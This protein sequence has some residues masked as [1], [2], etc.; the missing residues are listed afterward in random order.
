MQ[1]Q[2]IATTFYSRFTV[3]QD[4]NTVTGTWFVEGQSIPISGTYDGRL[5]HVVAKDPKGNVDWSGYVENATNIVGI[6]DNGK[7]DIPNQ[8]PLAF[9][10]EHRGAKAYPKKGKGSS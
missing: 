8:N 4:G 3:K 7:G 1:I 9:T 10:A 6:V 2:S 5:I